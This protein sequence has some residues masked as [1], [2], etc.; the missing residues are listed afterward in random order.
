VTLRTAA[1]LPALQRLARRSDILVGAGTVLNA[2]QAVRAVDAGAKFIVSPGFTP[3]VVEAT[4]NRSVLSL[5]GVATASELQLATAWGLTSVK[6]FP[7]ELLGGIPLLKALS[8]PFPE[9]RFMPSGG[10]TLDSAAHYLA[11]KE[12]FAIGGSWMVPRTLINTHRFDE[13]AR[14]SL[15]TTNRLAGSR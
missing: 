9:V 1:G 13:I 10:I 5:P 8:G 15:D 2:E 12:V 3:D 4:L 7:A 11:V 6:I 14:I